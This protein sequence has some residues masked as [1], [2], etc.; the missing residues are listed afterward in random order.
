MTELEALIAEQ[1]ADDTYAVSP[2][3]NVMPFTDGIANSIGMQLDGE[4]VSF[5]HLNRPHGLVLREP[6]TYHGTDG[7]YTN[8]RCRCVPCR[9]AHS[10]ALRSYRLRRREQAA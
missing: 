10:A 5:E 4:L 6:A 3:R 8:N 1:E 2:E 7:G 9:D